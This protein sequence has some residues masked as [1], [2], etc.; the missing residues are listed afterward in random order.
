MVGFSIRHQSL[1]QEIETIIGQPKHGHYSLATLLQ[2]GTKF[3]AGSKARVYLH[4]SG[5]MGLEP[6]H[7][8]HHFIKLKKK[9]IDPHPVDCGSL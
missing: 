6:A 8:G 3:W 5:L 4:C 2:I 9:K 7:S 1:K